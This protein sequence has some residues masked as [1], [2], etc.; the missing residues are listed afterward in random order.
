[1][2]GSMLALF[3]V[4]TAG[5]GLAEA[6]D[7][8]KSQD[9]V[10]QQRDTDADG[11]LTLIEFKGKRQGEKATKATKKFEKMDANGDGSVTREEFDATKGKKG[12]KK[13]S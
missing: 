12:E 13:A 3:I 6:K 1:M 4:G 9:D 7:K 11:K 2:I 10:F 5:V 8:Q